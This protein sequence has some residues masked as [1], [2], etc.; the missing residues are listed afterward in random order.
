MIFTGVPCH[1]IQRGNNREACFFAPADYTLYLRCLADAC[2]RYRVAVHAY[3]LMT[4]HEHLL[5]TPVAREG[6]SRVI[7]SVRRRFVQTII[8]TYRRYGTLWQSRHGSSLVDA[9]RYLLT[10]Y[11][12][13]KLN[14]VTANMVQHPAGYR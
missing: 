6:I 1:V 13:I 10:Y 11:R 3:V 5:M 2:T 8:K 12:Y 4:N 9:E 14:P 7:Q